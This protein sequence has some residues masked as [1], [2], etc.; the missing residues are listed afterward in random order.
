M[1][2]CLAGTPTSLLHMIHHLIVLLLLV[3]LIL[4]DE[5]TDA[6]VRAR[7]GEL[8]LLAGPLLFLDL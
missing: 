5:A 3:L 7:L 6:Y 2:G 8:L 4:Q 1:S